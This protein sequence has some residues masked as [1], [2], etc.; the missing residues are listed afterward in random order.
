MSDDVTGPPADV[1]VIGAGPVG[2]ATALLTARRGWRV[3]VLERH[4]G[5][6]PQPRAV[7]FDDEV[8]RLLAD[9]GLAAELDRLTE[10][11]DIYEW[12]NG[13]DQTLLRF[14][15]TGT[16]P[17][18]WPF[19]SM[20]NQPALETALAD[21]A[22]RADAVTVLRG[23]EAVEL[24]QSDDGV[25]VVARDRD[26]GRHRFAAGWAI[27]CDGANS[28]VRDHMRSGV[29]D[30][31]FFYDWLIVDVV[32]NEPRRWNP[33]N[34]QIC[35]PQRP[36]TV[37]SGG[38][39]RRR[40]E[41]MRMPGETVEEL[42]NE[43]TAWRLLAPW[44]LTPDNSVLERHAI[45]T[46]Q[47]RWADRWRDGRL[48]LA[49]DSAH[50]MPPFAGQ[51][52]CSGIR[53]AANLSWK[54]D[55]VLRG[56][57]GPGLLDS[58][59]PE[60]SAHVQHAIGLSVELGKVI[61]VTDPEQAAGRDAFMIGQDADPARILPPLPPPT[62][63]EG[64]IHREPDGAPAPGAGLLTGQP[65]VAHRGRTAPLDDITGLGFVLAYAEDP[66]APNAPAGILDDDRWA[67][68]D[69]I[70]ARVL[71]VS[72]A[73]AATETAAAETA[74]TETSAGTATS[75]VDR[76]VDVDGTLLAQ[77]SAAGHVA[78]LVRPDHYLFG[79]VATLGQLPSLVDDLRRQLTGGTP[80]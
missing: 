44:K 13:K 7:H 42:N 54:L 4:P 17:S 72:P 77:L 59:G 40:W 14:D 5:P 30:L 3:T 65:T 18:G 28:F 51:G 23:F 22:G 24:S 11:A 67:F 63:T 73:P 34:L 27:G 52:M 12:R 16:G 2:L 45:Y 35:D 39:G 46:F 53:D 57:A 8:A 20:F 76:V 78:A 31:G 66:S 50:L 68:L 19:A 15:W 55:L 70:G 26:G 60:R 25:E 38:P 58:Y 6:Y 1:L 37:V 21:A 80:A 43:A 56:L 9:A 36:T 47:A 62:L 79:G 69:A 61:C 71:P 10:P 29:T 41:F 33:V 49:G 74:A 48:L 75:A 64:I 32:P